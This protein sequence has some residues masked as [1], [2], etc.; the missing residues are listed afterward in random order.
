MQY[1]GDTAYL[2]GQLL[3]LAEA[4]VS[5]LDRGFLFG[6]GA[7]EVLPVYSRRPFRL[8][9]HLKRLQQSLDGIQLA[10]PYD[11]AGWTAIVEQLVAANPWDDQGIYLQVTRGADVKRDHPFPAVVTPTVFGM[12]MPLVMPSAEVRERGIAAVT[13]TDT[14][15]SRCDLKTTS[16]L[17][18]VLLRQQAVD[19]GAGETIL[20]RDGLLTEGSAASVL[21]VSQGTLIAPPQ[22]H[23]ILP[24]VTY[25][26]VLELAAQH[27]LP[28]EIRPISEAELRTA[29]EVWLLSS[30]KE[31]LAVTTLD[32]QPV[33]A[34]TPG[35][36]GRQMWQ[37]YQTFKNT[38]MRHG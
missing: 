38:V 31:V 11:L 24:G 1:L 16:L 30:T 27:G 26:V 37:W 4:K 18:N 25:D 20:L 14:R 10:N 9:Q 35:P 6:D 8:T 3:P 29:D 15:W 34:G 22:S 33:G 12:S 19:A 32:G 36:L 13:A 5:P 2:N 17:A 7:Y 21:I 28:S 23:L